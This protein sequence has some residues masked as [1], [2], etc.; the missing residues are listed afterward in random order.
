MPARRRLLLTLDAFNTLF[1][2]RVSVPLQYT[3]TAQSF[4]F[5]PP[6]TSPHTVQQEFRKA[7][8][9]Q[10]A[11]W[12]N[13]GRRT[14]GFGGPKAW[15]EK[16]IREC[17]ARAR[18]AAAA[19]EGGKTKTRVEDVPDA[20]VQRLIGIY[21]GDEGYALYPDVAG[22]FERLERLK[23][24]GMRGK[25]FDSVVVGIL[26]NADDRVAAI[27]QSFELRVGSAWADDGKL[28]SPTGARV[29]TGA[30]ADYDL[31]F[32]VT[33]YEAGEEKPHRGI[34]EVAEKRAMEHLLA[35]STASSSSSSGSCGDPPSIRDRASWSHVHVGDDY[36]QDYRGAID[37]GWDSYL[38]LRRDETANAR[39]NEKLPNDVK[40]IQ[41]LAELFPLLGLNDAQ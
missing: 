14:P 10:A 6:S 31:D 36:E 12:P 3:Q 7:F 20:L 39:K 22:F 28:L 33:S 35:T 5:L 37:A 17:F 38:L 19:D 15:W 4:G 21:E 40:Q 8:K 1:H 25:E 29:M 24:D 32:V 9:R 16:V 27:L 11:R 2:P 13:Y 23:K 41:T 26:S 34:Y 18:A 30:A